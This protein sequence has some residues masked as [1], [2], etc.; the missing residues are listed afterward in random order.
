MDRKAVAKIKVIL[1]WYYKHSSHTTTRVIRWLFGLGLPLLSIWFIAQKM[2]SGYENIGG[3]LSEI[4][5]PNLLWAVACITAATL[6]GALEWVWLVNAL[7]ARLGIIEG[8]RIHLV[9]NLTKYLPGFVWPYVGKAYLATQIGI[10]SG[11]ASVSLIIEFA[12][13][14]FGG[15]ALALI[16]LP[17]SDLIPWSGWVRVSVGMVVLATIGVVYMAAKYSATRFLPQE[18]IR[19]KVHL[20]IRHVD[21]QSL[22]LA[23][24]AILLTWGILGMGFT[25]LHAALSGVP[26]NAARL[27]IALAVAML[28]GQIIVLVPLGIGVR[29]AILVAFLSSQIPAVT[30]TAVAVLFRMIMMG[31]EILWALGSLGLA[32]IQHQKAA[33]TPKG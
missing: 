30:I 11:V 7:G 6:L 16:C 24:F 27:I 17:F 3:L 15:V 12:A 25:F 14:M 28:T 21:W 9:C 31:G 5:A 33:N 1:E 29:E 19:S 32:A 20:D 22:F 13:V 4:H 8:L 23:C 26:I 2:A 10:V 18:T